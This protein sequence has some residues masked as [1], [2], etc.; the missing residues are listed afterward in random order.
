MKQT[1]WKQNMIG[2]IVFILILVFIMII[3]KII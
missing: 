1:T 2:A 3:D